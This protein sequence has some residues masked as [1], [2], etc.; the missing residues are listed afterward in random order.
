MRR[1]LCKN[2]QKVPEGGPPD[3]KS[4]TP[5]IFEND[6]GSRRSRS[7]RF[8]R[9]SSGRSLHRSAA[10]G[11]LPA[12]NHDWGLRLGTVRQQHPVQIAAVRPGGERSGK[13][14]PECLR[15]QRQLRLVSDLRRDRNSIRYTPC[16]GRLPLQQRW[17][18][19]RQRPDAPAGIF[20]GE[21]G[22]KCGGQRLSVRPGTA[23]HQLVQRLYA[24]HP[25]VQGCLA[26]GCAVRP[27]GHKG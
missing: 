20:A 4:H 24:F 25:A 19:R 11:G 2:A 14:L 17:L 23:H 15:D 27:A 7:S 10:R 1:V 13:R 12:A 3:E 16:G 8:R 26:L 21:A 18:P 6:C 5:S 22:R 9:G